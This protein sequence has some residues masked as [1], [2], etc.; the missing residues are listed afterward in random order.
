MSI[1]MSSSAPAPSD[2]FT[3]GQHFLETSTLLLEITRNTKSRWFNVCFLKQQTWLL[4]LTANIIPHTSNDT[5]CYLNSIITLFTSFLSHEACS[6]NTNSI[7]HAAIKNYPKNTS[8]FSLSL[9]LSF[10]LSLSLSLLY[11]P[12]KLSKETTQRKNTHARY[13]FFSPKI[14]ATFIPLKVKHF[15]CLLAR[16]VN[17]DSLE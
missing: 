11:I 13:N 4:L 8:Y 17:W 16:S 6:T 9:S 10:S 2:Y 1:A 3:S 15:S 5:R 7:F 12:Y 14:I